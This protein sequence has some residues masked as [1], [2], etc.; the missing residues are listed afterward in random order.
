[1][2]PP[3]YR[4][5]VYTMVFALVSSTLSIAVAAKYFFIPQ[6]TLDSH[7]VQSTSS[8][9]E[10]LIL[11][12]HDNCVPAC[13]PHG[14]VYYALLITGV[15]SLYNYLACSFKDPGVIL[16]HKDSKRLKNERHEKK[17]M[18]KLTQTSTTTSTT[19]GN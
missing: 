17:L 16:R 19:E 18:Q 3:E 7:E 11:Y 12:P 15:L 2:G 5:L 9:L 8:R 14:L 10:H 13:D 4:W 6:T 1:M